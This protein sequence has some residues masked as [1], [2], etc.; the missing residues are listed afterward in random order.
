MERVK[1]SSHVALC[2]AKHN[3]KAHPFA[4]SSI[5]GEFPPFPKLIV[6]PDLS[7]PLSILEAPR[8][9]LSR[10][11]FFYDEQ[12]LARKVVL[13]GRPAATGTTL[14]ISRRIN[15]GLTPPSRRRQHALGLSFPA[16]HDV[17]SRLSGIARR[18]RE[19]RLVHALSDPPGERGR[20]R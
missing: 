7:P 20:Y 1:T 4:F 13:P 3:S 15:T 9:S 8:C 6:R 16:S 14:P 11:P 2:P 18:H 10:V 5:G 19:L 12:R 17:A